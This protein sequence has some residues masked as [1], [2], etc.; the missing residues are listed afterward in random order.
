MLKQEE[1][2]EEEHLLLQI[3]QYLKMNC[4]HIKKE[5]S[6]LKGQLTAV[7]RQLMLQQFFT[8]EKIRND[9]FSGIKQV[10]TEKGK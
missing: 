5:V 8:E 6:Q 7:S 9:G 10:R 3:L 1:E 2:E 4:L